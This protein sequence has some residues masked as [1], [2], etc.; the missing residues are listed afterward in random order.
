MENYAEAKKELDVMIAAFDPEIKVSLEF[1]PFSL[2]RHKGEKTKSLNW[3]FRLYRVAKGGREIEIYSGDYTKG[4][5]HIEGYN[6]H[7]KPPLFWEPAIIAATEKGEEPISF[8]KFNQNNGVCRFV[9]LRCAP[10][11]SEIVASLLRDATDILTFEEWAWEYGFDTESRKAE[12][13]YRDCVQVCLV[14]RRLFGEQFE[15]ARDLACSL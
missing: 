15:A 7:I 1:V 11:V 9:P 3:K 6:K 13:A 5:G 12:Q 10:T 4:L 2:S 14:M 8:A